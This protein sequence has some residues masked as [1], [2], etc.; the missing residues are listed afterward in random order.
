MTNPRLDILYRGPL[1]S[2]N[3]ECAYCPFAKRKSTRGELAED[4]G[5]LDR[6]V[7]WVIGIDGREIGVLFTPWGEA[8]IRHHYRDAIVRWSHMP[9]AAKVAFRTNLSCDV[10]WI[11]NAR[12]DR[13]GIWATAHPGQTPHDEL[14]AKRAALAVRAAECWH[15]RLRGPRFVRRAIATRASRKCLSLG[16]CSEVVRYGARNLEL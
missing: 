11:S 10:E 16:Q 7:D 9:H 12:A 1:S 15:R 4:R 5:A 6:F 13:V 2:C 14:I 3:Y 8:L